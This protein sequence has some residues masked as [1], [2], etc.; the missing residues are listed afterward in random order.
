MDFKKWIDFIHSVQSGT[1][2]ASIPTVTPDIDSALA[3][4]GVQREQMTDHPG[5]HFVRR[6]SP[7]GLDYFI[8]NLGAQPLDD[9]VSLS[10]RA[11]SIEV[12]DPMT[13]HTG[14]AAIRPGDSAHTQL[15]LQIAP[16]QSIILRTFAKTETGPAW[17]VR[18]T[19]ASIPLTG[20]WSVKFLSGGPPLPAP[21]QTGAL[22]SWTADP[23]AQAFAGTAL[24][25][26]TFDAPP[27]FNL[28]TPFSIDLGN[29]A[30]SARVRLNGKPLGTLIIPPWR[31]EA[32]SL[33]PKANLL[34][35]EVTNVSA[36]RIR[37]MDIRHVPWKIFNPP[38][39]LSI[40]YKPF[41]AAAWPLTDSGLLGPVTLDMQSPQK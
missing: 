14:L 6:S 37:D 11:R 33:L 2:D 13:G 32:T 22:A 21:Y 19:T 39:I 28:H 36:N 1:V 26:L 34:E 18:E 35:V 20:T 5:I 12:M 25:S 8:A 41:N 24:Y 16:G 9:S 17:P 30:Q 27:S 15:R 7:Y 10:T 40:D 31:V 23:D 4:A 38:N 3:A 29:V